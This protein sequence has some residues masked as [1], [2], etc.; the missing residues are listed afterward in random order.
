MAQMDWHDTTEVQDE[1]LEALHQPLEVLREVPYLP[2]TR[3]RS[4]TATDKDRESA[5]LG[6]LIGS[7][8]LRNL[9]TWPSAIQHCRGVTSQRR[10]N[11][12]NI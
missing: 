4:K 11:V 3:V 6:E 12:S 9:S 1:A 7:L 5:A 2:T 8:R 10:R